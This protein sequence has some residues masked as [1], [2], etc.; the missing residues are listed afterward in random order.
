MP[1]LFDSVINMLNQIYNDC[2]K[3]NKTEHIHVQLKSN[4]SRGEAKRKRERKKKKEKGENTFLFLSSS[5]YHWKDRQVRK[6]KHVYVNAIVPSYS[7]Q[8]CPW[9]LRTPRMKFL[10]SLRKSTRLLTKWDVHR[11]KCA[12]CVVKWN[13]RFLF[14]SLFRQI[15]FI[16]DSPCSSKKK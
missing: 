9:N 8:D 12:S 3:E 15:D 16:V 11:R 13:F 10:K 1:N 5:N 7:E 4:V 2:K 14:F 6:S